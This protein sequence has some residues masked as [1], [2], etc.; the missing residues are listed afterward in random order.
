[1]NETDKKG[2]M[3]EWVWMSTNI[4]QGYKCFVHIQPHMAD[5]VGTF[6]KET[7]TGRIWMN[8]TRK[9]Q[10]NFLVDASF[11]NQCDSLL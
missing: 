7:W 10:L 2:S 9:H 4:L 11:V 6:S 1:M 5:V 8:L 3:N